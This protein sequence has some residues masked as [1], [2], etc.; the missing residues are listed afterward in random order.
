MPFRFI[1]ASGSPVNLNPT[2][3]S[4]PDS[5]QWANVSFAGTKK[6]TEREAVFKSGSSDNPN[7]FTFPGCANTF[8]RELIEESSLCPLTDL[9]TN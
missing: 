5:S 1:L 9:I 3:L 4:R 2:R 8:G 6:V 7:P